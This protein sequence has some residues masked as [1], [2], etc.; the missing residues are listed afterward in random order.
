[1]YGLGRLEEVREE[2]EKVVKECWAGN[3]ESKDAKGLKGRED[4][5]LR[6]AGGI[7]AALLETEILKSK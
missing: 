3:G 5:I 6:T 7:L 2:A 1:M 4:V